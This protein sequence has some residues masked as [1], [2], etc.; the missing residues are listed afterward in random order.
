MPA[1]LP[2]GLLQHFSLRALQAAASSACKALKLMLLPILCCLELP[3]HC[4]PRQ[5]ASAGENTM[6]QQMCSKITT[7]PSKLMAM[8]LLP[9]FLMRFASSIDLGAQ[10][11][12]QEWQALSARLATLAVSSPWTAMLLAWTIF[13]RGALPGGSALHEL[14]ILRSL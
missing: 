14:S 2:A 5:S 10:S 3:V 6:L 4:L 13:S 7:Q 11:S 1:L 12:V 9:T 8:L